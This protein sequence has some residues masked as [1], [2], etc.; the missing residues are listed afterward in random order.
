MGLGTPV[1]IRIVQR[2]AEHEG[3]DPTDLEPPLYSVLD[4]ETL[5][6]LF[7]RPDA[8]GETDVVL[9]FE[10]NGYEITVDGGDEITVEPAGPIV[11][12]PDRDL[13]W[14]E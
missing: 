4:P 11:R 7:H 12:E 5:D 2:V 3:V 13:E 9:E 10:Y 6:R 14:V 8:P 1:G